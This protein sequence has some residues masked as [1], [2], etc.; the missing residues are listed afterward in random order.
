MEERVRGLWATVG[1]CGT[2]R[3]RT[4]PIFEPLMDAC[5]AGEYDFV[6]AVLAAGLGRLIIH[7]G[8][9]GEDKASR[10]LEG[11]FVLTATLP[12]DVFLPVRAEYFKTFRAYLESEPCYRDRV[13]SLIEGLEN[14]LLPEVLVR[15]LSHRVF[16]TV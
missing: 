13:E 16:V 3:Q 8:D 11:L 14:W 7:D 9:T 15:C 4:Q 2:S 10:V 12:Y 1:N 6:G 5:E